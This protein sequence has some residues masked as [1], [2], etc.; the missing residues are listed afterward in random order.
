MMLR[1]MPGSTWAATGVAEAARA[2]PESMTIARCAVIME[3]LP[4]VRSASGV[5][6]GFAQGPCG[7]L[8]AGSSG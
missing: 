7:G 8:N 6:T 1:T 4:L 2:A 5:S 3:K